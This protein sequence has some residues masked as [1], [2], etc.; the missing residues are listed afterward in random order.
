MVL[1][2]IFDASIGVAWPSIR[3]ELHQPLAALGVL[4][5]AQVPGFLVVTLGLGRL[6]PRFGAR[7][8]VIAAALLYALAASL[9]GLAPW[10]GVIAGAALAGLAAGGIDAPLN[11][12]VALR[13]ER[14]LLHFLHS[15]WGFGT[16]LGPLLV[17]LLLLVGGA[18]RWSFLI[19]A[20]GQLL[21]ALTSAAG[22]H[23]GDLTPTT[24]GHRGASLSMNLALG[25]F[26]FFIYTGVETAAG[27]WSF[28]VLT[29][30]R[31]V[32]AAIA[33][34]LVSLY[35][36]GLTAGRVAGGVAA[37]AVRPG[38]LIQGGSLL[39][40]LAAILF[41]WHPIPWI[42]LAALPLLGLG[43]APIFP[44]LMTLTP[45]RVGPAQAA[46]AIGYQAAV[47]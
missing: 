10:P 24:G 8:M 27:Q 35:W 12:Y 3:R 46:S 16:F 41:W 25:L 38:L 33:G 34:I 28:T 19:I 31:G 13:G 44:G 26:S 39:A 42:G 2:G 17:T 5:L 7:R 37:R 15:A 9:I 4:L 45:E 30:R 32:P 40:V 22:H 18:P 11:A 36:A 23:W 20:A 21:L 1:L 6:L 47:A 43:L 29:E 14:A